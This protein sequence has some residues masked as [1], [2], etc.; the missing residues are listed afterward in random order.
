MTEEIAT[1]EKPQKIAGTNGK[2]P[3]ERSSIQFPYAD[4]NTAV[5]LAKT[6]YQNAG[7][8]A[9]LDQLSAWLGH[10]AVDGGAFGIKVATAR[11]F[12]LV[13]TEGKRILLTPLGRQIVNPS[14]EKQA[15]ATAFL[16]VP[17]YKILFDDYR[18]HL[19]PPNVGLERVMQEKGVASK[20][21]DRARQTFQRSAE[22]AGFF[23]LGRDKLV[24]PGGTP[25]AVETVPTREQSTPTRA[26]DYGGGGDP[27][28][29]HPFIQGLFQSLPAPGSRWPKQ[30][31]ERWLDTAKNIFGIIYPIEEDDTS[32]A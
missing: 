30:K 15:R 12:G 27:T 20:Q 24:L 32:C 29:V 2:E 19:L 1:T 4:L 22:Q 7:D 5:Q 13:E 16:N 23:E 25:K 17:L 14:Q 9:D 18:G 11:T 31:Q 3:R 8:R 28:F 6:L 26:I 10:Q 21:T